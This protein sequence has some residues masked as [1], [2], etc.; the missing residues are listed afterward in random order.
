MTGDDAVSFGNPADLVDDAVTRHHSRR[1]T[2]QN[3][4]PRESVLVAVPDAVGRRWSLNWREVEL[5]MRGETD[6]ERL[7]RLRGRLRGRDS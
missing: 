2:I 1:R 7:D 3:A 6:Q 4:D 5:K